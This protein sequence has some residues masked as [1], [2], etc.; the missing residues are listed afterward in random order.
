MKW[1]TGRERDRLIIDVSGAIVVALTLLWAFSGCTTTVA[2][3]NETS[4]QQITR[5]KAESLKLVE[6][7]TTPYADNSD[8][9]FTVETDVLAAYEFDAGRGKNSYTMQMWDVI[10]NP[11]G[12][13][14][15]GFLVLWKQR[16]SLSPG[17]AK[18]QRSIISRAWNQLIDA[19]F[20]KLHE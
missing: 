9:L 3:F 14:F 5:V 19:E 16:G 20:G 12:H 15:A 13:T 17:F 10:L 11:S 18:D 7:S 1:P 6:K 8:L 4:Y 2:R